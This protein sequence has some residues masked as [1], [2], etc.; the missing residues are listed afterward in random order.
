MTEP[1]LPEPNLPEPN[2][3]D[4]LRFMRTNWYFCEMD[5]AM[6]LLRA[7]DEIER[8][9]AALAKKKAK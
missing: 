5:T 6:V 2:L 9:R 3:P 4:E 8:L 1:N 7:A